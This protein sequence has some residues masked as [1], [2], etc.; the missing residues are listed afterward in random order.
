MAWDPIEDHRCEPLLQ[1]HGDPGD[2]V[3]GGLPLLLTSV[4][5]EGGAKFLQLLHGGLV[6]ASSGLGHDGDEGN[7]LLVAEVSCHPHLVLEACVMA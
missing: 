4:A 5:C 7:S 3:G 2:E 6:P 1:L